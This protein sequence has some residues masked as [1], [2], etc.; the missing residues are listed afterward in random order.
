MVEGLVP[1]ISIY[2]KEG[3]INNLLHEQDFMP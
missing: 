1:E 3:P 2:Y